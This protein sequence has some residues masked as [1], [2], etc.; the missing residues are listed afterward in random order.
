MSMGGEFSL[1]TLIMGA[2]GVI[3]YLFIG[4]F[5]TEDVTNETFLC[6]NL[7]FTRIELI[8]L[9]SSNCEPDFSSNVRV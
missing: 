9:F 5:C 8:M 1:S 4:V 7:G 6:S 3:I 2:L